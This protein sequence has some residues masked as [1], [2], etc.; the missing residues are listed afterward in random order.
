MQYEI[1]H[2]TC[3]IWKFCRPTVSALLH[4]MSTLGIRLKRMAELPPH[5]L[6]PNKLQPHNLLPDEQ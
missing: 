6:Q 3:N 5:E 1:A 2:L 4:N